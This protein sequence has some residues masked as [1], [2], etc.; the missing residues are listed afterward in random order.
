M[1]RRPTRRG[2]GGATV[3]DVARHAGV[4]AM[5]VS[6]VINGEPNVREQTRAKVME[7]VEALGYAPNLAAR[8]LAGAGAARIGLL[9]SN[10][11]SG[12]LSE[13]LLGSLD[14]CSRLALQ[15]SV[16][17]CD[18]DVDVTG[19]VDRL[20]N[21]GVDGV[22]LPPPLSDSEPVLARLLEA[23]L[24]VAAV[25]TGADHP[26]C[27][28]VSIDDFG[29][30][31]AMTARLLE[32]GHRR[33]AFISGDPNQTA[34]AQRREGYRAALAEAGLSDTARVEVDGDFS[35]Q[36]GLT[37]AEA[38]LDRP[39]RP[40]AIFASNDDMAAA[41]M[42]AAH[43]RGLDVP[44]DISVVGFDDTPLAMAVWPAMTT[45]RQPV[46]DMARAAITILAGDIRAGADRKPARQQI[47]HQLVARQSDGPAPR[48]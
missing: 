18:P 44:G 35:F 48:I 47:E 21:Q 43:R 34:S 38:L 45:I 31:K 28:L 22:I 42:S 23:G 12:Y 10:P 14:Q 16:E 4:S 17:K 29:A 7:A 40:T 25:A 41:A 8:S 46:A 13:F 15:L 26:G 19:P 20:I 3:H 2:Q 11:S 39:E 6:R 27:A 32:L 30:S 9:Y 37:A 5:T 36:S 1:S 24:P 33:I